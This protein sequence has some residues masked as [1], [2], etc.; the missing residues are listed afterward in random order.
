MR[1]E[2][3]ELTRGNSEQSVPFPYALRVCTE[4]AAL[5]LRGVSMVFSSGDN[6]V[7]FDD[8]C[9][10]NDG[11]NTT[12]FLPAFP[13]SCPYSITIGGTEGYSPEVAVSD[14]IGG[15]FG[16]GGLSDYASILGLW[17]DK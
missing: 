5:G 1:H 12:K 4:I 17:D 2:L 7:G 16:G 3:A 8:Q 10:S 15:F 13:A 11:K 6:G 14:K 9:F